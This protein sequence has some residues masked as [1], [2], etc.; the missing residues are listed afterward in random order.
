MQSNKRLLCLIVL[1]LIMGICGQAR[2]YSTPPSWMPMTMLDITFDPATNSLSITSSSA[3]VILGTGTNPA[4]GNPAPGIADFDPAQSWSVLN[5]TAF[6]RRLG[7]NDP[8][9]GDTT[10]NAILD[11]VRA[12]YGTGANIWIESLAKSPGLNNYLAVGHYGVNANGSLV[13]DLLNPSGIPYSPIFGTAGSSSKWLWDGI[14]DHNTN[15]VPFSYLNTPNQI[16]SADY[17]IYVGDPSGN[18]LLVDKNG[19]AVASAATTTTWSWQGPAFVFT[20]QVGVQPY[21]VIE[22]DIFT[23]SGISLTAPWS[24]SS[25]ISITGGEYAV[26][27]DNGIS[28]GEWTSVT[29]TIANNNRVKVRQT[30]ATDPGV[31]TVAVLEIPGI[32]GP[33]TFRVTTLETDTT[34]DPFT[35]TSISG[36]DPYTIYE[37]NPV[38]VT[39]INSPAPITITGGEY[40]V[41]TNGGA[42]WSSYSTAIPS[43]IANGNLVKVRQTSSTSHN[44][45]TTLLLSI[46]GVSAAF[47]VTTLPAAPVAVPDVVGLSQA[48]AQTAIASA[49]LMVGSVAQAYSA[50]VPAGSVISQNPVAGTFAVPDSAVDLV[51][52]SADPVPDPFTFT[53]MS[54]VATGFATASNAVTIT[55]IS[56]P[57]PISISGGNAPYYSV[58]TDNGTTWSSWSAT[59][60]ATVS[61]NDQVK[62]RQTSSTQAFTTTATT[63][64]VGGTVG[65]FSVTTGFMNPPSWMPMSMLSVAFDSVTEKLSVVD[66]ETK[67]GAGVYPAMSY[68]TAGSYEPGKPWSILN[69]GMALSRQLGWDDPTALHGNGITPTG[70]IVID[71]ANRYGADAGIWIELITQSPGLETYFADGMWGVGGTGNA[72]SGTPQVYTD[73]NG[74]PIIYVDNYHGIFATDGSSARW[75]WDGS[76][77]HNVYAVP[78][79]YLTQPNQLFTATYRVYIGDSAGNDLAPAAATIETWTW[80]GPATVPDN[81]PE[82][83]G[84]SSRTGVATGIMVES[85]I[86]TVSGI[87]VPSL[88]SISGGEYSVSTDGGANWSAYTA[89]APATVANGN[90][91]KVRQTSS[92]GYSTTTSA[93]LTIGGISGS[94]D[95]TTMAQPQVTVPNVVGQTQGSAQA[96]ITTAGLIV[97]VIT[98]A[99]S[100]TIPAG[101]VISQNPA[102]GTT[103][104][105][106]TAVNLVVS[107]GKQSY[108]ITGAGFIFPERTIIPA[109]FS[110]NVSSVNLKAGHLAFNYLRKRLN[111]VST[112]VASIN[113]SNNVYTLSGSG[114]VNGVKGY[115][116]TAT[117]VT[118]KPDMFGIVIKKAGG[119]V[120]FSTV[121]KSVVKGDIKVS[122]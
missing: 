70:Q 50:T 18:E 91:V 51:V 42:D 92:S 38:T 106:G 65:S 30:S 61:P 93:V 117:I 115:S 86:I 16:F 88:I 73:A 34:P 22:S 35:F 1:M 97:G 120:V 37:S 113:E 49:G 46:G 114:R 40:S 75:R 15:A 99:Y 109:L 9:E 4:N 24:G 33:G 28:W 29:G 103:V 20:S 104:L 90:Q 66:E 5:G 44:T 45:T 48:D 111:L 59:T 10:G 43:S 55:G 36:A 85:D 39:G 47:N 27:I 58:S 32:P 74:F 21:A 71:I 64:N 94:F 13:V 54:G 82:Q 62:V 83:F 116:Y 101:S 72:A 112:S 11:K 89:N 2:A 17:R 84:F 57:A 7:W 108:R 31:T 100:A 56:G 81:V 63:L 78:A 14:M 23:V 60:P 95:I 25:P 98:Q 67:L 8:N 3:P 6:S 118:G 68:V 41:S 52:S 122:R 26:S 121:P 76:M 107:K 79:A 102:A 87:A 69:G 77:I 110:L 80:K 19:N 12:Y 105:P 53:S 96:A 119:S